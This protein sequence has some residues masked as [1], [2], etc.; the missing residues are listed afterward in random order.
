MFIAHQEFKWC[1]WSQVRTPGGF[2]VSSSWGLK[3][4]ISNVNRN[5]AVLDI[6]VSW[7]H[8]QI[9]PQYPEDELGNW[10]GPNQRCSSM[11]GEWA[12]AEH[13]NIQ[14]QRALDVD[15]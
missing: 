1:T 4:D 3:L 8:V 11:T 5:Q 13:G 10:N 12:A 6:V 2:D 7:L 14:V 9:F 15:E